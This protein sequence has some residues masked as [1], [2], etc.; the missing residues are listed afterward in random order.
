MQKSLRLQV[1]TRLLIGTL[2]VILAYRVVARYAVRNT[3]YQQAHAEMQVGLEAC[4]PLVKQHEEFL[5]CYKKANQESLTAALGDHLLLCSGG[6]TLNQQKER[7]ACSEAQIQG[8]SWHDGAQANTF[9]QWAEPLFSHYEWLGQRADRGAQAPLLLMPTPAVERLVGQLW[10]VRDRHFSSVSPLI[11]LLLLLL[12]FWIIRVLLSPLNSLANSLGSLSANNFEAARVDSGNFVEFEKITAIYQDMCAR[13]AESFEKERSFTAAAAHELRTPLTILRGTSER[14]IAALAST[15][16]SQ[17]LARNMGD[18]VERL[19]EISE[20][21]L[22]LSRADAKALVLEREDFD[23]SRYLEEFSVDAQDFQRGLTIDRH[24]APGLVWHCD[25]LLIKQLVQNLYTNAVKYNCPQGYILFN[26]VRSAGGFK[27][28][29]TNAS[30]NHPP[31]M[32]SRAF[33][34]FYRGDAAHNRGV[35]GLGLGLSICLEIAKAHGATL[36][37][38][39]AADESVTV[40]LK[41]DMG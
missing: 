15:D 35:D 34:R 10:E 31:D 19:I 1:L 9:M 17:V 39:V 26:L 28:H 14:L 41:G 4:Q 5:L 13:L 7:P 8:V 24:V 25:P 20:K 22:L 37:F 36:H 23:L 6:D 27:F 3:I 21:L 40:T 30:S 11:F 18:E 2:V 38:E 16:P 29:I 33:D 12:G 32:A